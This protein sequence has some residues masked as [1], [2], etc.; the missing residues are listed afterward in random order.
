MGCFCLSFAS[1][2]IAMNSISILFKPVSD[3]LGFSR[4]DFT[5]SFTVGA[6]AIMVSAPFIGKL[7]EKYD[8]RLIVFISAVMLAGSFG[9]FSI[10]RSLFQFYVVSIMMGIGVA[11]TGLIAVSVL[12]TNWFTERRGLAMGIALSASGLGGVIYNPLGNWFLEQY[13]WQSTYLLFSFSIALLSIPP[14]FLMRTRPQEIGLLPYGAGSMTAGKR[15]VEEE[16]MTLKESLRSTAFWMLALMA[17]FSSVGV[18]GVQ[19]H[20]VAFL[21]DVGHSN[22]FASGVMGL[23]LGVLVPAK[24]VVGQISDKFGLAKAL[25][26]VFGCNV[27]GI[28][29]FYGANSEWVAIAAAIFFAFGIT[30]QTVFPPLMAAKCVGLK[31][32]GTVFGIVNLFMMM[33]SGVGTPLSGYF[34]D[35]FH[36]YIPAFHLFIGLSILAAIMGLMAVSRSKYE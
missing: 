8:A 13:S 23:T 9:L 10:C 30:I 17:F 20:M 15:N 6:L 18:M 28:G 14:A 16:G 4:G 3:A 12:V 27:I 11:S 32:F 5:L 36:S 25:V 1:V 34:Y 24:I 22:A 2:G 19:M 31:H 35:S 26:L 33:G 29:L 7:Y 21:G